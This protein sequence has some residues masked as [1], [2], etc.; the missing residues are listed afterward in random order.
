MKV[1]NPLL[2]S[3]DALILRIINFVCLQKYV[4]QIFQKIENANGFLNFSNINKTDYNYMKIILG[5]TILLSLPLP[6]YCLSYEIFDKSYLLNITFGINYYNNFS[7]LCVEMQFSYLAYVLKNR[8]QIIN[9]CLKKF[10]KREG[11]YL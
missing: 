2:I 11:T 10:G 1:F 6:L 5:L 9:T 7:A 3:A 4:L 8:F